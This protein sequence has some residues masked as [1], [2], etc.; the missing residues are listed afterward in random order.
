MESVDKR[1]R[2]GLKPQPPAYHSDRTAG[3]CVQAIRLRKQAQRQ[4]PDAAVRDPVAVVHV[5]PQKVGV[6]LFSL[7]D[8]VTHEDGS[9]LSAEQ[10]N[11]VE[12]RGKRQNPLWLGHCSGKSSLQDDRRHQTDERKGLSDTE[13][14]FS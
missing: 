13:E 14:Q 7:R 3:S 9:E 8:E 6:Q 12:V 2:V 1:Q 11:R 10:A 4:M 5:Q